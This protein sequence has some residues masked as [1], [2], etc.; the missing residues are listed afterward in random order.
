MLLQMMVLSGFMITLQ[1]L[2]VQL[3][4][5]LDLII[6]ILLMLLKYIYLDLI[7]SVMTGIML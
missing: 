5:V 2:A 4:D 3:L 7:G 1:L 6:L